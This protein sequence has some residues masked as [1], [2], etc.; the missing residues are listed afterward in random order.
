[1]SIPESLAVFLTTFINAIRSENLEWRRRKADEIAGLRKKHRLL[2]MEL[3]HELAK[4]EI[5]LREE[6]KRIEMQEQ[7]VTRDYKE[8]LHE[9]DQLK[10]RIITTFTNMPKPMAL[11]IHH[12]A[13]QMLNEMWQADDLN[14]RLAHEQ[15]LLNFM[16]VI[17]DDTLRLSY[18]GELARLPMKTIEFMNNRVH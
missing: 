3:E 4:R 7:S 12:H 9:I 16:S 5:E 10:G 18:E 8:F 1:M 15:K 13:K 17:Y 6:I 11:L 14:E 2:D